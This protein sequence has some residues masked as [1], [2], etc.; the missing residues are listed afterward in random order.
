MQSVN[1]FFDMICQFV[2]GNSLYV[3]VCVAFLCWLFFLKKKEKSVAVVAAL[4]L[5]VLVYNPISF[6]II[7]VRLGYIKTYYRFFWIVP[8][9]LM[10]AYLVYMVICKIRNKNYRLILICMVCIGVLCIKISPDELK[11]PEN[12]W[13]I[14]DETLEVAEQ[15]KILM[16]EKEESN[17]VILCDLYIGNTI[18]QYY[19]DIRLPFKHFGFDEIEADLDEETVYGLMSMLINNRNDISREAIR[20]IIEEN[21]IDYLVVDMENNVSL[22]YMQELGWQI[23]SVTSSYYILRKPEFSIEPL[24]TNQMNLEEVVVTIPGLTQEYHFLFLSDLHII[25]EDERISNEDIETVHSRLLWSSVYEGKSAADYWG[26]L[27]E[28]LDSCNAD[29]I[30]LGGDMIDFCSPSNVACLKEGLDNTSTP[31]MYVRADHDYKPYYC[32]DI[33]EEECDQ[34]HEGIDGDREVQLLELPEVCIVGLGNSTS[35]LSESALKTMKN[36]FAKGKTVILLTHVPYDSEA[37]SDLKEAS[38]QAW[39]GRSLVWGRG[40]SYYKTDENTSEFLDI[41]Y[42]KDSPVK[43]ILSGHLHFTW[44]G[45]L[46]ENIHQHVFSPAFQ[47]QVGVITVKGTN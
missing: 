47:K 24:V 43:E 7:G 42:A 13:Q 17:A 20:K 25:V 32:E 12:A 21:H 41:L 31:Y 6:Q 33:T 39:Q 19:A 27:M 3:M 1:G 34:L 30:L 15:L 44:D 9:V 26:E 2:N 14:P 45:N 38:K 40:D 46:T 35:P 8:Y 18:R 37:S 23:V 16:S 29:A 5:I 28:I 4:L 10:L 11:L 22:T 36:M